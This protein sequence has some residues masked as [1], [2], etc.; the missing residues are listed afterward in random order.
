[1]DTVIKV[2]VKKATVI[3]LLIV[4]AFFAGALATE[5]QFELAE[6]LQPKQISLNEADRNILIAVGQIAALTECQKLGFETS[7]IVSDLNGMQVATTV[8]VEEN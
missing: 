2:D 7:F 6:L 1:M 3:V 5:R 8:C 4:G